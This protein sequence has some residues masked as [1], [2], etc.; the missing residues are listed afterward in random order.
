MILSA[1]IER[2]RGD[3]LPLPLSDRDFARFQ[4]LIL[5]R[6]GIFLAPAKKALLV[7]RL[8]SRLRQVGLTRFGDYL[9]L[10]TASEAELVEMLDRVCTNETHFFRDPRQFEFLRTTVIPEWMRQAACGQRDR[11]IR[12]WSAACSSGE[13]PYSL[14][15][16]LRNALDDARPAWRIEILATDLSTRILEKARTAIWP[17]EKSAEIPTPLLR[18]YMLKGVHSQAGMIKAAPEIRSLVR[19][20]RLNLH[21]GIDAVPAGFDAIFCRN[22]LIYFN[23]EGKRR[24]LTSLLDRL[25][26]AGY[27]FLGQAET[28]N[29]TGDRA[30]TAG[31]G[32][33]IHARPGRR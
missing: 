22:V 26:P 6:A 24:V 7:G 10:V 1:A 19:F 16:T 14:A 8:G 32:A 27:L 30:R 5:E 17:A 28:M 4:K 3:A 33:Y 21:D 20:E 15:M 11:S 13:E 18:K 12:I 29:G 25:D 23:P 31:P 9:E 2:G